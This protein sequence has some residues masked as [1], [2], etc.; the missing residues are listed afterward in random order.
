M[1]FRDFADGPFG[2][3]RVDEAG[4]LWALHA[5]VEEMPFLSQALRHL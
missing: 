4:A 1:T 2:K 5:R 3:K